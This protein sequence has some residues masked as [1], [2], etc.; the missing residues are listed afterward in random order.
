MQAPSSLHD[1]KR[2]RAHTVVALRGHDGLNGV[3]QVVLGDVAK[4]VRQ[5]GEGARVAVR[6]PHAA[7]HQQVVALHRAAGRYI[8]SMPAMLSC[9]LDCR[10]SGRH[11][12]GKQAAALLGVHHEL[13]V[14]VPARVAAQLL[15]GLAA[16]LDLPGIVADDHHRDIVGQHIDAVVAWH[17]DPN[18]QVHCDNE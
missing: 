11:D 8:Y 13:A 5:P 12:G 7:A 17:C 6:P 3:Q 10:V 1:T 15:Q 2:S 18:L 4:G 9:H 16:H 14:D